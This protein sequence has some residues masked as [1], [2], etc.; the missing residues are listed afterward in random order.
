MLIS[1]SNWV[2]QWERGEVDPADHDPDLEPTYPSELE[3]D[4]EDDSESV[5]S[6]TEVYHFFIVFSLRT[7]RY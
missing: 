6:N 7:T 3:E 2:D 4:G 5:R 1:A